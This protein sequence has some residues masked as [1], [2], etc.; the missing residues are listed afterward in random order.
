MWN[1][2]FLDAATNLKEKEILLIEPVSFKDGVQF[3]TS[4]IQVFHN[5]VKGDFIF[6]TNLRKLQN[7]HEL[8]STGT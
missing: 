7:I 2:L 6:S 5:I 3:K 8:N 4:F 1:N